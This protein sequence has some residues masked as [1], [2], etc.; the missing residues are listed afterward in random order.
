MADS[1]GHPAKQREAQLGE[2]AL[3]ADQE[4]GSKGMGVGGRLGELGL[5]L[6]GRSH[7]HL[8]PRGQVQLFW[9]FAVGD[10]MLG[11]AETRRHA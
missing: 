5:A 11:L 1:A 2:T 3:G 6:R 7:G 9:V 8:G 4:G 10:S